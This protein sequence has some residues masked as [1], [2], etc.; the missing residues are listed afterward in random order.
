[1]R[2]MT[3]PKSK[4]S[5]VVDANGESEDERN[6]LGACRNAVSS[7]KLAAMKSER[8]P[9]S[10]KLGANG[11]SKDEPG[12]VGTCRNAASSNKLSEMLSER[13]KAIYAIRG[14]LECEHQQGKSSD[15]ADH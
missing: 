4:A 7:C 15:H 12:N 6:N 13:T 9:L 14:L 10:P 3:A 5:D 1:M 11:V 2:Q 8:A